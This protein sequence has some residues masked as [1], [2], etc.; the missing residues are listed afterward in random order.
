M[1]TFQVICI[2]FCL[3]CVTSAITGISYIEIVNNNP[4]K[5]E[6]TDITGRIFSIVF[7]CAFAVVA[8]GIQ[9]RA[10][11]IWIVG[12]I[13]FIIISIAILFEI[14]SFTLRLPG[15]ELWV[16]TIGCLLGFGFV[17]S[18]WGSWW[19]RQR[20]YFYPEK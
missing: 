3:L 2:G 17:A 9:K 15:V 13:S 11:I 19:L 20:I 18:Y 4:V 12:S 5:I 10:K 8:Y 1:R 16:A 7:A 14:L 6:Y